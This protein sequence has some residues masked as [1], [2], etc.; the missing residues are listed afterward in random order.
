MS[1]TKPHRKKF[2]ELI[3]RIFYIVAAIKIAILLYCCNSIIIY[4]I[5]QNT[6]RLCEYYV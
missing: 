1:A 4:N 6:G 2:L 3:Q 5:I